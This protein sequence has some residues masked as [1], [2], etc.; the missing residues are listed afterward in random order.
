M[1]HQI[2]GVS[3]AENSGDVIEHQRSF[4]G[5]EVQ[6]AWGRDVSCACHALSDGGDPLLVIAVSDGF[7]PGEGAVEVDGARARVAVERGA[8]RL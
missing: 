8:Q 4:G 1:G 7:T 5:L 2:D 6:A 3:G